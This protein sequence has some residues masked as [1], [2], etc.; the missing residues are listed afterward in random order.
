MKNQN[1]ICKFITMKNNSK[2]S[3]VNF[4]YEKIAANNKPQI[5]IYNGIYL[6]TSGTGLLSTDV[7]T[8]KL[9]AGNIFFTFK[10][11]PYEIINKEKLNYMYITFEGERCEELFSR[12]GISPNNCIFDG[13][14]GLIAFWQNAIIRANQ[15]NLDLISESV[16]L[17][18]LGGM[19]PT[20]T[21][22][23][24]SL[25]NTIL[26]YIE[27]NFNDNDLSLETL[28]N[29]MGYNSKY[30]SRIFKDSMGINFSTYL[31]NTRI[32]YAV[33]L[34]EQG[35]TSIKNIAILCGYKDAFYFSNVFKN[36]VGM[37]PSSYI[38]KTNN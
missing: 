10:G 19:T 4:V 32:Q 1:N 35:V 21:T 2:I 33:F 25:I 17:Y 27:D 29:T 15:K 8:N 34:I 3:T 24:D 36:S 13:H 14:E 28:S 5:S 26:K 18:T 16:L 31:T 37:S 6:V 30:I 7:K 11:I 22:K 12:F 9:K 38:N 23:E 20:E